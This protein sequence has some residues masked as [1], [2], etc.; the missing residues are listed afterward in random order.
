MKNLK[1]KKIFGLLLSVTLVII[2]SI[3]NSSNAF[4]ICKCN[5]SGEIDTSYYTNNKRAIVTSTNQDSALVDSEVTYIL[6]GL[7]LNQVQSITVQD[8]L[9]GKPVNAVIVSRSDTEIVVD[10]PINLMTGWVSLN[11]LTSYNR[12]IGYTGFYME[13]ILNVR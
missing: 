8:D 3:S 11:L 6:T 9:F 12:H 13:D 10:V 5:E 2:L 4:G 7:R 1:M